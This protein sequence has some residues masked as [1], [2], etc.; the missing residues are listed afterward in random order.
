[1]TLRFNWRA[2]LAFAHDIC[3][4]AIAWTAIYWLRFNLELREPFV[5]DMW[6]TLAWIV[7]LQA[8]IFL[9]LG[10]YRGLWRYAS[11]PDLQRIV[12]A[13]GLGAILIPLVLVMLK[14]QTVV[15]RSVLFFY[16][17]V[18]IFLMAGSRFVYRIW[19]EHRLYSPLAALGEPVLVIGAGEAG[20]RLTSEMARSRQWRVVG[21]LDDDPLKRGRELRNVSVLGPIAELPKW[22]RHYGVRKVIIALPSANHAV[23]RRVAELCADANVEALTVPAY[24]ELMSGRSPLTMLRNVEL[25]DLLGRDP[26]VLDNAGIAEWLGNRVVMVTGAG[27]SIGAELCRQIARFRPARLVMFDISE[28]ALYEIRTALLD[29]FPQLGMVAIVGDVKHA[30][31]VERTLEREKPDAIFHA[32]AY[33]HVPLME[34]TNA[35]QAVL[36]NAYGTWVIANAAVAARVEKFVLVSTDKA[37]N[38]TSVMGATKRVAE[39]VCQALQGGATQFVIVRFGNVFGSAGSVIPR[40]AEQIARGG[41]VTVTHP[42]I[43]RYFM[44]LS[45]AT[46]LLLQAGLQGKGG[47]ILALDMGE[48]V[49]IVDLARDMIRLYGADPDRIA[50]V[51]TGLRPG[52]K[53]YEEPLASEEATKP[54]THPKLHIAQARAANRDAVKQMVAW[55]DRDRVADDGEV[56]ARMQAWIPEYVPPAGASIKPIPAETAPDTVAVPLRAPRRR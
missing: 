16:P 48:P 21:L 35:W 15:P 10:L 27:G 37:V 32:A 2:A 43:T 19:K 12:L 56:R 22:I 42:D 5:G 36:N 31:L 54:T 8:T 38:P 34:E 1:M 52:E 6:S 17:I 33:K 39:Q 40:F 11:L 51:F 44:S 9:S 7:P 41:P 47:E 20:A 49:R 13:A 29:A 3:M 46:Q 18:L 30:A 14:L 23:R 53:L 50:V 26:V 24:D 4:T 55:C 25:D 28:A 45:E